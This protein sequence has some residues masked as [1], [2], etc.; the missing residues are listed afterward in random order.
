MNALGFLLFMRSGIRTGGESDNPVVTC[1]S[2]RDSDPLGAGINVL[3][4]EKRQLQS[5][6]VGMSLLSVLCFIFSV[7]LLGRVL[8]RGAKRR[9]CI[10]KHQPKSLLK[11]IH[12]TMFVLN[13]EMLA[14]IRDLEYNISK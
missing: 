6:S 13:K 2:R 14:I 10:V 5:D 9:V 4:R 11:K 12:K 8:D 3:T 7:G 1:P